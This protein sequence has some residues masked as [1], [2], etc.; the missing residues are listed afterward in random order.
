MTS[1]QPPSLI[2]TYGHPVRHQ[3][4]QADDLVSAVADDLRKRI[5]PQQQMRHESFSEH[6]GRHLWVRLIM[7]KPIQR[8]IE[9]LDL[10]AITGL[11][12]DVQRQSRDCFSQN[13]HA[14]LD[15]GHLHRAALRY[16]ATRACGPEEKAITRADRVVVNGAG[17]VA[18]Q[19]I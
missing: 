3:R 17:S 7:K 5:P 8:M 15:G 14:R 2:S 9:C 16:R 13:A 12:A 10:R 4:I 1:K 18:T 19:P 6:E 11:L